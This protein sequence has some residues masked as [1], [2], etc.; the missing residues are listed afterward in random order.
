[1]R[2]ETQSQPAENE[3]TELEV[4]L[5]SALA[6]GRGHL[7]LSLK[8]ACRELAGVSDK[9]LM[10]WEAG[11][12]LHPLAYAIALAR[13]D[14]VTRSMLLQALSKDTSQS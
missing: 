10:K 14:E 7:G 9:T 6:I 2:E 11:N 4:W 1:M 5:G 12:R 3:V 8:D 13:R